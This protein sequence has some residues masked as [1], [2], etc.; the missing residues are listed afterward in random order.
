[1]T[2]ML[3]AASAA[4]VMLALFVANRAGAA[5]EPKAI[6]EKAIKAHGGADVLTKHPAGS[7]KMKGKW[8]GMGEGLEY[9]GAFGVQT[10][11]R[12]HFKIE[13]NIMGQAFTIIQAVNGDK[14]WMSFNGKV[15]D[16]SKEQLAE[17]REVLHLNQV[18]RLA[19][20][21]GKEYKLSDLGESKV[22]NRPAVGIHVERKDR[23]D[24]NL[25][26]DRES[27]LLVKIEWRAK[28]LMNADQE[29]TEERYLR[30]YKKVGEAMVPHKVEVHRD[31]KLYVDG[32]T[33]EVTA[34]DKLDD[35]LFVKP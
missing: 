13:M 18:E 10:P 8:Y 22:D 12:F 7:T 1:M 29:F 34:S 4:A 15:S 17:F 23:R 21:T 30:D 16:L 31:N 33:L 9:T 11:D 27:G 28:D 32:E 25:F 19:G 20:L 26:F 2:T 3:R 35:A 14:G 6:I 24:I 5:D